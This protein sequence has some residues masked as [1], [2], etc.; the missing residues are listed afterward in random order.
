MPSMSKRGGVGGA[1]ERATKS[2]KTS[3]SNTSKKGKK[4]QEDKEKV[5]VEE[6]DDASK[7]KKRKRQL[8]KPNRADFGSDEDFDLAF[9]D[10]RV[11]RAAQRESVN[12]SREKAKQIEAEQALETQFIEQHNNSLED[13]IAELK[14]EIKRL[15]E[16]ESVPEISIPDLPESI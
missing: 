8:T 6:V 11:F 16:E 1:S 5:D 3:T 12:K 15:K 13:K 7:P 14:N 9:E 10:W 2:P 4:D